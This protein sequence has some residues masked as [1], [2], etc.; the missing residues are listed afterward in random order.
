MSIDAPL[1]R[2]ALSRRLQR[3]AYLLPSLFTILN[4]LLGFYAVI[5]GLQGD[6]PRAALLVFV[7]AVTDSLDGRIARMT[8]TETE[9][10]KEFDSLADVITFGV[11]PALLA[12]LW[13]VRD[14]APHASAWLVPLFY[15]VTAAS[16]LARFNVQQLKADSRFFVG[17][18]VP[19][20]A[21]AICSLLFFAPDPA[22]RD[23]ILGAMV[24]SLLVIGALMV[25]TFRYYSFK[26]LDLRRRW[27]YRVALPLAAIVVVVVYALTSGQ[28]LW[29]A[30][31]MLVA[32]VYT[33]SGP[34][35]Y[36]WHRLLRR[37]HGRPPGAPPL[38]AVTGPQPGRRTLVAT[39]VPPAP[40]PGTPPAPPPSTPGGSDTADSPGGPGAPG[41]TA[42]AT[43]AAATPLP[44]AAT[45]LLPLP[46]RE[47]ESP[48]DK[49][50]P[51]DKD[52]KTPPDRKSPP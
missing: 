1:R 36:L 20:A 21:V 24:V 13:G 31:F 4:V 6:F 49:K 38:L 29:Q 39:A 37:R 19:A 45:P 35:T 22:W 2:P 11:T 34:A 8:G 48:A 5:C 7:A 47:K 30:I 32:L 41:T 3:G 9:F 10:G 52:K 14:L 26:K 27:S 15:V 44:A 46:L 40:A 43:A 17:L 18:P 42:T 25:S 51:A 28:L 16:R 23:W 33:L 12:Y 50:K